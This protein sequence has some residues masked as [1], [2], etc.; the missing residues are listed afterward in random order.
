MI[1][2]PAVLRRR[3]PGSGRIVG[4]AVL[5]FDRQAT[6]TSLVPSETRE[7]GRS[8]LSQSISPFPP[9]GQSWPRMRPVVLQ[10]AAKW[11]QIVRDR[12]EI[13]PGHESR[14]GQQNTPAL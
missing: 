1:S 9:G 7:T 10:T 2:A 4:G 6:R 8:P 11:L 12:I 14:R 5:F 3:S 13:P